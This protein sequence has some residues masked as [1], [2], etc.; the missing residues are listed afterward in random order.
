M[1][2]HAPVHLVL[3]IDTS[4]SMRWGS[5]ME[6][7]RRALR[8]LPGIVGRARPALAGHLQSG[9]AR[10]GGESRS[11]RIGRNLRRL[12]I[13]FPPKAPT[14]IVGGLREAYGVAR[15]TRGP[16]RPAVRVVLLTDG[17]LD[18]EP[19][20]AEKIEKQA[21]QAA[22]QNIPLDVIDLG[23]QK[24]TDPQVAS[25][26]SNGRG[27]VHRAVSAE[28]VRWAL[29]EIVT[30]RS[31]VVARSARLQVTFNPKS[32]L[33]YRLLG[34]ESG[35][36]GGL[37]PGP[38]EADFREGQ[39]ATALFE[40]RLAPKGPN[41]LASVELTW[42]VPDGGTSK[43]G[44]TAQKAG[45]TIERKQFAASLASSAPSLQEAAAV[46]YTAEVLRH[47]P[48]IFQRSPGLSPPAALFRAVELSSQVDSQLRL[49]PS[50]DEF[51]A[52]I[53]QE[54]KAHPARRGA[55][56]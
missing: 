50:F 36:W 37:L 40:V 25:L 23:Q 42:Y 56:E 10:A 55:K 4:T 3:L 30:G 29:R 33:E 45:R 19:A 9:R 1:P 54:V 39:T 28:Q 5:R 13:R 49:R 52:L 20:A 43:A 41:D 34:H 6:I 15:P 21:A 2:R 47:S 16:G 53:R 12:P 14:N 48:F 35:D 46:A 27:T 17:L 31:Q 51:V 7:V 11:R 18:L 22:E 8:D 44:K 38:L 26:A 32:V 24:E